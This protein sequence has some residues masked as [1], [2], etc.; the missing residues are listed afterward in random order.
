MA[1]NL[2]LAAEIGEVAQA[3]GYTVE[4]LAAQL[5]LD[6]DL[7]RR[8]LAGDVGPGDLDVAMIDHLAAALVTSW[9]T[10][11]DRDPL[12]LAARLFE[13]GAC[14][15]EAAQRRSQLPPS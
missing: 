12:A 9:S 6:P 11:P 14:P 8:L 5:R 4:G 2:A 7:V 13:G 3:C 1:P 15:R 10:N